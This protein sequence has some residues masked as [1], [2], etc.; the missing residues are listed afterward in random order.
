[1]IIILM[2]TEK[3]IAYVWKVGYDDNEHYST[4][5]R[6][7]RIYEAKQDFYRWL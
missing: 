1:M 6:E 2:Y 4:G 3:I 5:K 7:A